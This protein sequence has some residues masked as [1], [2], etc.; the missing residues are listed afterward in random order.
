MSTEYIIK[1]TG[2]DVKELDNFLF[3]VTTDPK[4]R[5]DDD[6]W[7][8]SLET[9]ELIKANIKS[10]SFKEYVDKFN[11]KKNNPDFEVGKSIK[12]S[13]YPYQKEIVLYCLEKLCAIV[14]LPCGSGK[15]CIGISTY[16]DAVKRNLITGKGLIVVKSSLKMQWLKEVEKFSDLKA[17]VVDTYK[18]VK[19]SLQSKVRKLETKLESLQKN[20]TKHYNEI[21][22]LENEISLLKRDVEKEF[23]KMFSDEYDL[24]IANYETLRD[25][26][27]K[28]ILHSKKLDFIFADEVHYIKNDT[29][30]RAKALCEFADTK[31]K[32]GATATPIQKNPLDAYSIAKF[33][34]PGTFPSKSSFSSRY[35]RYSGW[36]RV[37]GS[38]NEKELNRKLSDFMIIKEKEE[39]SSQLPSLVPITRY[40]KLENKQKEMTQQLLDE[41]N[42]LKEEEKKLLTKFNGNV[43]VGNEDLIKIQAGIMARQTFAAEMATSEE[44]L[45]DSESEMAKKYVTGSKSNKI[46][47]LLDLLEEIIESGEKAAIFSKYKRLQSILTREIKSRFPDTKIAYVNGSLSSQERYVEVYEKFQ[48]K[49][50][51]Y[52]VLLLSDAGAEGINLSA[53][54]YLI[55][56]EPADS[57]LIQTQR[58]G[59]IERAD[60]I[61]NTVFVYQLIAEDSYD[62]IGLKIIEKKEKYDAQIIKGNI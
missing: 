29:S 35:L 18:S 25:D 53:T 54:K 28:K 31:M 32:I 40:C 30:T 61:H 58:R 33:I 44:L 48:G 23:E 47:L 62:E 46:E 6:G 49:D 14:A 3:F 12:L 34:S 37:T 11:V 45:I 27:V 36:G 56:M 15:S 42:E 10:Y 1:Y 2:N 4:S 13:L 59:R 24:Y 38:Q 39:V 55:E 5:F 43:P 22:E 41:I 17:S 19:P 60:S 57:Y 7:I 9:L 20:F 8:V 21:L 52:N 51:S 50:K 26:N 16:I